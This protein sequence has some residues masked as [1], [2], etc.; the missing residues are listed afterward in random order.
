[1]EGN[2]SY[3]KGD[4]EEEEEGENDDCARQIGVVFNDVI[5]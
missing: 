5:S 2:E 1:V 4:Q 3:G